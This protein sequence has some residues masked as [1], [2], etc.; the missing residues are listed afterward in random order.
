MLGNVHTNYL[1]D[2]NRAE[3]FYDQAL[4]LNPNESLAWLQKGNARSFAGDG[5]AALSLVQKA[6]R[7]SPLDPSRHFYLSILASAA[8]S[9]RDYGRAVQAAHQ[10]LQLNH[11]HVSTHRV[12]AIALSM[13]GRLDEAR[14]SV[15]QLLR[16]QPRLTVAD[17][18]ARSPGALSGL[19]ATFGQ[20]LLAA[21]L[22]SGRDA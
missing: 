7:L 14:T 9:A 13:Q 5:A 6:T 8:L 15:Q 21:G 1:V 20:A 11:A 17:F 2:L 16:L 10:A 4:A 3:Q 12:L 18:I 22:P 19:A